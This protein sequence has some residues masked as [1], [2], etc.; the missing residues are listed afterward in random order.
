[1]EAGPEE[2][3]PVAATLVNKAS[4]QVIELRPDFSWLSDSARRVYPVYIDPDTYVDYNQNF[5]ASSTYTQSTATGTSYGTQ[6]M[7]RVGYDPSAGKSR[8]FVMHILPARIGGSVKSASLKLYQYDANSCTPTPMTISPL[9]SYWN[10]SLT[11]AT[12]PQP[13]INSLYAVTKSFAHGI[14]GAGGCA[15]ASETIDVTNMVRAWMDNTIPN[16]GMTLRASETDANHYK[17]FCSVNLNPSGTSCNVGD[18]QPTLTITY[19]TPPTVTFG[20]V[21]SPATCYDGDVPA[22]TTLTPTLTG[23]AR[24]VDVQGTDPA[25]LGEKVRLRFEVW[26]VGATAFVDPYDQSSAEEGIT[27][28]RAADGYSLYVEQSTP[29]TW[30]VPANKLTDSTRYVWRAIADDGVSTS[31]NWSNWRAF[32]T[33]T[34][35]VARTDCPVRMLLSPVAAAAAEVLQPLLGMRRTGTSAST[36]TPS[37]ARCLCG[38]RPPLVNQ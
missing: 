28:T 1:M 11:W 38:L 8:S 15:N 27:V 13:T 3:V 2:T 32:R 22:V 34:T 31:Q 4:G 35:A 16:Y 18:R 9:S 36:G 25:Q 12:S 6:S 14:D 5:N 30:T 24:D 29:A 37:W 20:L 17:S 10:P 26:P 23:T 21:E 7:M 33:D 19:N